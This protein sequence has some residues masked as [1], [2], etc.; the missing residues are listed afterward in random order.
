MSCCWWPGADPSGRLA[1]PTCPLW[2][3]CSQG[4]DSPSLAALLPSSGAM[5]W[6]PAP[7]SPGWLGGVFTRPAHA[8][9]VSLH[10][11]C[12]SCLWRPP[13]LPRLLARWCP[14]PES[15]PWRPPS[16]PVWLSR[17]RC[18][19]AEGG[20]DPAHQRH[21]QPLHLPPPREHPA[22]PRVSGR[23]PARA[24]ALSRL[25][26]PPGGGTW[27]R[28]APSFSFL[29]SWSLRGTC[30]LGVR[31]AVFPGDGELVLC[32]L[33]RFARSERAAQRHLRVLGS[34]HD[35]CGLVSE[36]C[37]PKETHS[38]WLLPPALPAATCTQHAEPAGRLCP[39]RATSP[40]AL[41]K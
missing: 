38:R 34:I 29:D 13:H 26:P 9:C 31:D 1:G 11:V 35:L 33:D 14:G 12:C 16:E 3:M 5:R 8:A 36:H 10:P 24:G 2:T 18:G 41:C 27:P 19:S 32:V 17:C 20:A 15:G 25:G 22:A 7:A 4:P 37:P 40:D 23:G 6:A 39:W 30:P 21:P 28:S